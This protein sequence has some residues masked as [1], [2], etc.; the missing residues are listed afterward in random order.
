[1]SEPFKAQVEK[2]FLEHVLHEPPHCYNPFVTMHCQRYVHSVL[3]A[4]LEL[5][6]A[7]V[8]LEVGDGW[9]AFTEGLRA[10]FPSLVIEGSSADLRTV[11][12]NKVDYYDFILN[13][14]VIEHIKDLEIPGDWRQ[15]DAYI[16]D[17]LKNF[18]NTC[19]QCLKPDGKMFLTTPNLSSVKSLWRVMNYS[20][21][22][23]YEMHFREF[24]MNDL[25]RILVEAGFQIERYTTMQCYEQNQVPPE[26]KARI[27]SFLREMKL[28][29]NNREEVQ[30]VMAVKSA[31]KM[32][33]VS[34]GPV[35]SP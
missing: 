17:G 35:N 14:E 30:F 25:L 10:L 6:A 28:S 29:T 21:P 3:F 31:V 16:G 18:V 33:A 27:L 23:S 12:T 20:D 4:E 19:Y 5:K 9:G 8:V 1:M 15:R 22:F 26:A 7:K 11:F 32:A 24:S 2:F 13:M 34:Q